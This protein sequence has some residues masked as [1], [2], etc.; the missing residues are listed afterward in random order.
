MITEAIKD[1]NGKGVVMDVTNQ[2]SINT[3]V[4]Q[5]KEIMA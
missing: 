4:N 5:I 2:D 3:S 1:S